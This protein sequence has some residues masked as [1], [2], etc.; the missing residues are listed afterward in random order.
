MD[1]ANAALRVAEEGAAEATAALQAAEEQGARLRTEA[2]VLRKQLAAQDEP[3]PRPA[4]I[5]AA[6]TATDAPPPLGAGTGGG[7]CGL[8]P[9]PN[10]QGELTQFIN[11]LEAEWAT[12]MAKMVEQDMGT[13]MESFAGYQSKLHQIAAR[14]KV[15]EVK[16]KSLAA[17]T[18]PKGPYLPVGD[19]DS[20]DD[21]PPSD[22]ED[23]PYGPK[24]TTRCSTDTFSQAD[25]D[26]NGTPF[27]TLPSA[28]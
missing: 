8:A 22:D 10:S 12:I 26:L 27:G 19:G 13:T 20:A 24:G 21:L 6:A 17:A 7:T 4:S 5:F 1:E 14:K 18:A 11:E 16:L 23:A 2:V 25:I 28:N 15:A 9:V 3:P